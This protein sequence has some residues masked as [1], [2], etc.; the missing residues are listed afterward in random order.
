MFGTM[1]NQC[2][3][4]QNATRFHGFFLAG[5]GI[6]LGPKLPPPP[7]ATIIQQLHTS[8]YVQGGPKERNVTY[9]LILKTFL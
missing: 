5:W 4:L 8:H 9:P 3:K 2:K 7:P 6:A 1:Q